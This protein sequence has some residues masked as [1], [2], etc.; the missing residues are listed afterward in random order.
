MVETYHAPLK[1]AFNKIR[2]DMQGEATDSEC[3]KMSLFAVNATVGPE[4][5]FPILLVFGVI[6][7]PEGS[8]PSAT[9]LQRASS[10]DAA[11]PEVEKEQ[12]RRLISFGLRHTGGPK[13]TEESEELCRLPAGSP[14][15]VY[16]T[17]KKRGRDPIALSISFVRRQI[18]KLREDRAFTTRLV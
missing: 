9:Q 18:Y 15:M 13:R 10:L 12:A 3:M 6:P 14:V 2:D 5:L 16:R 4:G 1:A 11:M 7:F 8:I 17:T